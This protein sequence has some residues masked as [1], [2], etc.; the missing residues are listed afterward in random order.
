VSP[1]VRR[2]LLA[3]VLVAT[4]L[5]IQLTVLAPLP[6]PGGTPDLVLLVVITFGLVHGEVTGMAV[7]FGAGL[8]LDLVPPADS[9]VGLWAL[10]LCVVG[11]LAGAARGETERSAL[12]PL[13]IVVGLSLVSVIGFAGMSV[14]M[15]SDR[16]T[17]LGLLGV[18]LSTALYT[19]LLAPFVVPLVTALCRRSEPTAAR[20]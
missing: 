17:W 1:P 13:A 16:V 8:A 6:L 12:A 15:G 3:A 9:P 7:G 4:A 19:V 14:L 5:L 11:Y 18:A 10:V 2:G 20:R